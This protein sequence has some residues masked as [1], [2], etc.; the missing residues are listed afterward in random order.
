MRD[1][2]LL[3]SAI[4]NAQATF[5]GKDLY[6]DME[7]KVSG[8]GNEQVLKQNRVVSGVLISNFTLKGKSWSKKMVVI[9][10]LPNE[11]S[12]YCFYQNCDII[13]IQC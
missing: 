4:Y 10:L 2:K 1:I 12:H 9:K 7:S 5:D 11:E 3:Q 8:K 6:P 13:M